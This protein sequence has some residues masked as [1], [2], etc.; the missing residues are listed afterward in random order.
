MAQSGSG[1]V[2]KKLFTISEVAALLNLSPATIRAWLAQGR[3]FPK[4]RCG[5]AV[6][7][8]VEDVEKFVEENTIPILDAAI[9]KEKTKHPLQRKEVCVN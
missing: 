2:M 6:R 8:R 1:T 9:A 7:I 4:V 3:Y 5:R